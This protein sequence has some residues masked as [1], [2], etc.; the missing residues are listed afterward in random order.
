MDACLKTKK[1]DFIEIKFQQNKLKI[2]INNKQYQT[3]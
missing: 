3:K 1:Q 2:R